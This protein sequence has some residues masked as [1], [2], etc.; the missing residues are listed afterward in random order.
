MSR[1]NKTKVNLERIDTTKTRR[2]IE[3][4]LRKN[5]TP[6]DLVKVADI[7][8][9]EVAVILENPRPCFGPDQ[10]RCVHQ[11]KKGLKYREMPG[12]GGKGTLFTVVRGP[13]YKF[14]DIAGWWIEIEYRHEWRGRYKNILSLQDHNIFP[15][16]GGKWNESNWL[17]FTS[18]SK[19]LTYPYCQPYHCC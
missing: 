3:D 17:A 14:K 9:V 5:A 12:R 18:N 8:G 10:V 7:L 13:F 15:Y 11:I 16:E 4:A 19:H 6:K 1:K 2:R